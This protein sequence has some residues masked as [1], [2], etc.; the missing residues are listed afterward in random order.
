MRI[1]VT[2]ATGFI[3]SQIITQLLASGYTVVACARSVEPIH[4]R[5]PDVEAMACDFLNDKSTAAWTSRLAGIDVVINCVGILHHP[6]KKRIWAVHYETPKALFD[7]C[8]LAGVTKIIQ[9]SALG[10]ERCTVD[11]ALSK[12]AADDYLALLPIQSVIVRPSLVYGKS[13]Y[14]GTSLFRGLAGLPWITP[15][16]GQ[17]RQQFQPILIND[18]AKAVVN[19]IKLPQEHNLLLHAVSQ[20]AVTLKT[21]LSS[22]RRWL[23]FPKAIPVPIPQTLIKIASWVGNAIPYSTLNS[24]SY[25]L[26]MQDNTTTDDEALKFAQTVGFTPRTFAQGI[27]YEPSSVQDRWHARLYFIKPLIRFTLAFIWLFTAACSLIFYPKN[28]SY[29]LLAHVGA[30]SFWQPILLYS[31]G[32]IDAAIGVALVFNWQ[33][34]KVYWLQLA[35]ITVYS[36]IISWALP[37]LWLEPFA[38]VAKNLPILTLILVAMVLE[39]D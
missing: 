9:I 10:I 3:A 32:F 23:G 26:M 27:S 12:K 22:I 7:A 14:G 16:V 33:I 18:L 13:S 38:P 2:G 36:A 24:N 19:L 20:S 34:K 11:Y 8:V 17:G 6:D 5:F 1:L 15:L 25:Q 37:Q 31:A 21:V 39:S 35:L 30:S 4:N 29:E 28:L